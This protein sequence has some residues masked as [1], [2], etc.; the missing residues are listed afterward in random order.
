MREQEALL[1]KV[2]AI[3]GDISLQQLGLDALSAQR[4]QSEVQII[5]HTAADIRLEA[6]ILTALKAN[7]MGTA[8]I[9]QLAR[10]C[11]QLRALV[12]TSSC[13]VNMNQPRSSIVHSKV[14]PLSLGDRVVPCQEIVQVGRA[15]LSCQT[16]MKSK[17]YLKALRC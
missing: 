10:R 13:F 15:S 11:S 3:R 14:Y 12:H 9:L 16:W 4:L 1:Q 8:A 7:Y 17:Q 6:D 2:E 5:L